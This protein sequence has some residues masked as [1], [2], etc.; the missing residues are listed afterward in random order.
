M[1]SSDPPVSRDMPS[2]LRRP[3][4]DP[5]LHPQYD[6]RAMDYYLA[7]RQGFEDASTVQQRNLDYV[8]QLPRF[9]MSLLPPG[10][11]SQIE[12][13]MYLADLSL[14][15]AYY[16]RMLPPDAPVDDTRRTDWLR[17]VFDIDSPDQ[18]A[19]PLAWAEK[20]WAWLARTEGQ[21]HRPRVTENRKDGGIQILV[22]HVKNDPILECLLDLANFLR[23]EQF[24][25][26]DS[27]NAHPVAVPLAYRGH[28]FVATASHTPVDRYFAVNIAR[29]T[30]DFQCIGLFLQPMDETY[31]W[32][33]IFG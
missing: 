14:T 8:E 4:D 21:F 5:L 29:Q 33:P 2:F 24:A 3:T 26:L 25:G 7:S 31:V 19:T 13:E 28:M 6:F 22:E 15:Q 30:V 12:L 32:D 1:A 17:D 20:L 23:Y 9:A 10:I 18:W 11:N 27:T 16:F